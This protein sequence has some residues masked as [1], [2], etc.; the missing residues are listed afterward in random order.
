MIVAYSDGIWSVVITVVNVNNGSW[1][2]MAWR[3]VFVSGGTTDRIFQ[4]KEFPPAT[5]D[6]HWE[7]WYKFDEKWKKVRELIIN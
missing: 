3:Y 6:I 1:W 2:G 4:I 5:V 7:T